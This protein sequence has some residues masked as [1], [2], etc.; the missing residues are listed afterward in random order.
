MAA[1]CASVLD[2]FPAS[3]FAVLCGVDCCAEVRDVLSPMWCCMGVDDGH[4]VESA[5][6]NSGRLLLRSGIACPECGSE[7]F[8]S[9]L[10]SSMAAGS[11]LSSC[12]RSCSCGAGVSLVFSSASAYTLVTNV[13]FNAS[14]LIL[15]AG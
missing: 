8:D 2:P 7:L 13:A 1:P 6:A 4:G 10:T 3:D 9:A 11:S 5:Q 12:V 15:V 14:A